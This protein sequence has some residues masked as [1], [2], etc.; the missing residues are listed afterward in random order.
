MMRQYHGDEGLLEQHSCLSGIEGVVLGRARGAHLVPEGCG[1]AAGVGAILG[2]D[3]S[4]LVLEVL[5]A[6]KPDRA[7]GFLVALYESRE[8]LP[9]RHFSGRQMRTGIE[10]RKLDDEFDPQAV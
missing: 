6:S 9:A 2:A 8:A 1:L 10:L 4:H 5:R 7:M 3:C